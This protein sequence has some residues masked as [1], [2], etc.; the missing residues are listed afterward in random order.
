LDATQFLPLGVFEVQRLAGSKRLPI[1]AE[2][3]LAVLIL[4]PE[5]VAKGE[6]LLPHA[7]ARDAPTTARL[8]LFAMFLPTIS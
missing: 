4:D 3:P 2:D 5:V 7:I 1:N 6:H 8:T